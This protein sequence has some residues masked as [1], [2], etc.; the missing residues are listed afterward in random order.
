MNDVLT[1]A[2]KPAD[3]SP[4]PELTAYADTEGLGT[5]LV[6]LDGWWTLPDTKTRPVEQLSNHGSFPI[7]TPWRQSQVF[8]I[9]VEHEAQTKAQASESL[10]R[11]MALGAEQPV[12]VTVE[13]H[14]G[15]TW[16][17]CIVSQAELIKA[18]EDCHKWEAVLS[19]IAA[20][21]RR[22]GPTQE[23]REALSAG[24]T[25]YSLAG[26]GKPSSTDGWYASVGANSR[27]APDGV[28]NRMVYKSF[29]GARDKL[30]LF[31]RVPELT[32]SVKRVRLFVAGD[33][34]GRVRL[35]LSWLADGVLRRV[36]SFQPVALSGD[37]AP[38]LIDVSVQQ[39]AGVNG[40]TVG[41]EQY[42]PSLPSLRSLRAGSL[43][44]GAFTDEEF[45]DGD[46][47]G[48]AWLGEPGKSVAA[49]LGTRWPLDNTTGTAPSTPAIRVYAIKNLDK[50]FTLSFYG[51][52]D[53]LVYPGSIKAGSVVE[54]LPGEHAVLID[55]R[56]S[57]LVAVGTW[58]VV[59]PGELVQ[60]SLTANSAS[61]FEATAIWAPAWW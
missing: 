49:Q 41:V 13:D 40:L 20:D 15:T 55:G 56:L 57:P 2:I 4:L 61:D 31:Y 33:A 27:I 11:F 47:L 23:R 5:R 53:E 25:Q 24:G 34:G 19:C 52:D 1:V 54:L 29:S 9:R 32:Y 51:S 12:R 6:E 58:P 16:R 26:N 42:D 39:P 48:W 46:S 50:G 17:D 45:Q 59:P 28:S 38:V 30:A 22:Y 37:S 18:H 7:G 14:D 8:E 35:S 3:G 36:E 43:M 21:P 44:V 60:L 10:A